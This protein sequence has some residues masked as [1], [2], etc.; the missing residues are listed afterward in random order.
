[1]QYE[2]EEA[3]AN[4]KVLAAQLVQTVADASE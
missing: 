1:M 3:E 2:H 4:E